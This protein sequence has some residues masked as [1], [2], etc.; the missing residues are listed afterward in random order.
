MKNNASIVYSVSLV[1]GDFLALV[2]AFTVA[3]ILRVTISHR[4]LSTPI[5]AHVY[6]GL[7]ASLLP[8]WLVIFGLLGL[9]NS[10]I[11]DQR[12]SELGRLFVGSLIGIMLVV[13]YSYLANIVIFPARLVTLYG[14]G[15]A[16]VFVFL[17]RTAARGLRRELFSYGIGINNLLLV[18]DT[19]ITHSLIDSLSATALT[20]YRVLGVVGGIKHPLKSTA[21]YPQFLSFAEAVERLKNRHLH[22]IVQTELYAESARN[23]EILTYAQEN[24]VAY[25]FVPGN[26]ELFV[27]N[28]E[29]DLFQSVPVIAV[30]QTALVGWGR[31]VKRLFDI[32]AGSLA[33]MIAIPIMLVLA[34]VMKLMSRD[35]VFFKQDRLSRFNRKVKIY[36]LRT[37]YQKFDG[38]TPEQAFMQIG[39]PELT[40]AYRHN[41]DYLADDPRITPLGQFLRRSSLDELPQLWNVVRGDISLVGPRALIAAELDRFAQKNLILSVR[42]GLTGLAQISGRRDINFAERRKLDLYYVQN[43]SFWNDLVILIKTVWMVLFHRG[44]F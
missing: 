19:R 18:G 17:I 9:Y 5:Q 15:L 13:S 37:Q 4:I 8:L 35:S 14:F 42:S 26:S 24:H 12:F 29:V 33:L 27:G 39:R 20:G 1:I 22:T 10:R 6:I 34:V 43:W 30:H 36:K 44:A 2:M 31:V 40:I 23:D 16:F 25:R 11:H 38:T 41:G 28:I 7:V 3:Y 21:A 32:L